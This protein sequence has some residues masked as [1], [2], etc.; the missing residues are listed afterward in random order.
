MGWLKLNNVV[1]IEFMEVSQSFAKLFH[2]FGRKS[3]AG[4]AIYVLGC[5]GVGIK[6]EVRQIKKNEIGTDGW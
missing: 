2:E 4:S 6:G 3:G 1:N 5:G